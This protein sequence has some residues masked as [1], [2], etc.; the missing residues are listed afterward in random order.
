M[1]DGYFSELLPQLASRSNLA[2]VNQLGFSNAPLRKFLSEAFSNPFG[3]SGSFLADPAFEAVFGWRQAQPTLQ[4][5]AGSLLSPVLVNALDAPQKELAK[6]YR[7]AKKLH[8]YLHQLKAWEILS[9]PEPQSV[10]VA[11]G[12]GSGK[13][14]C[15]MVPILDRLARQREERSGRLAGVRALFL[16][17]LN[18][19]INSQ[20]DRLRAWT[21]SFG[22]DIRFCLYNGNTPEQLPQRKHQEHPNEVLDREALR[23]SPPPILVTNATM[24]EYMLVRTNDKPILDESQGKLEWVVLDEAHT[25]IGSQAAE[26]ALLIRRV[27]FAFGVRSEDVRFVATSATIG[28]PDGKGGER[29]RRFLAETAGVDLERV[30]LISGERQV[31]SLPEGAPTRR[32]SLEVLRGIDA[33]AECSETRY[34]ALAGHQIARSLRN[35]FVGNMETPPIA[36]LSDICQVVCASDS[37]SPEDQREALQWLDLLS[38]T[39]DSEGSCFLPLRA[40]VFHQTLAGLWACSNGACP[41]KT[42]TALDDAAWPFGQVY[43]NP[44]KHCQCG[45]PAYEVVACDECGEVGL[46]AGEAG[47]FLTH[48]QTASVVDEFE[49]EVEVD[50]VGEEE[51]Q[52]EEIVSLA[53]QRKVLVINKSFPHP[54]SLVGEMDIDPKSRR[55]TEASAGALRLRVREAN[56]AGIGCPSCGGRE[57]GR[58]ELFRSARVGAPFLLGNILPTMLEYA[59]DGDQP[60]RHPY[61]GRRLLTFNDS[62]QGAARI[63]AK[64]QQDAERRRVRSLIYHIALQ[65]GRQQASEEAVKLQLEIEQL[66]AAQAPSLDAMIAGKEDKLAALSKPTPI[67]FFKLAQ[68]ISDQGSDF[69]RMLKHYRK[70][71]PEAF[72]II[73]GPTDLARLFLIRE[74]G[75]RPKRQNNLETMGLVAVCYPTLE[76]I[77]DVPL[78]VKQV[79]G[80]TAGDWCDF[81]KLCLDFFIRSGASLGIP[82]SWRRWLGV[83]YP[84]AWVVERDAQHTR[85]KQRR[86]PRARRS[87]LQNTLVRLLTH[88]IGVDIETAEGE[89]CIDIVLQNAWNDLH[90]ANMFSMTADGLVT[91]LDRLAFTPQ[92]AAWICPFTRRLLDTTLKGLSPYLPREVQGSPALCTRVNLPLY[93]EPFGGTAEDLDRVRRGRDWLG[94]Q[95]EIAVLRQEGVWSDLNDRVIELAPFFTAAEHSAQQESSTLSLYEKDFKAG[96]LNLLSCSTTMEMGIDIGGMAM[97][98]MN[99]VP[100]HPANYLQRAGRAGRRKEARSVSMTLCKA[101]PHDQAVFSNSRWAFDTPLPA[102]Q[103]SLDSKLIVQRHIN[104]YLLT[105]YLAQ[106]LVGSSQEKTKLTCGWFFNDPTGLATGFIAWCRAFDPMVSSAIAL[107]FGGLVKHSAFEGYP[108]VRLALQAAEAMEQVAQAWL[109]EW[110]ALEAQEGV[111]SRPGGGS[112]P[113][114]KAVEIHKTRLAG[115]YL[116]RELATRGFLPGYGFPAHISSFDNLTADQLKRIKTV[117]GRED[118]R[119]R[120][121]ELASRDSV[122]ALREYAPG[123]EVVM[124]GLVFR[125][126]G[127]TLN[128]HSPASLQEVREI[129]DIRLAWRCHRCGASGSSHVTDDSRHCQTCGEEIRSENIREFLA[130]AG[131]AVDFYEGPHNDVSRQHFVPVE[132][133]WISVKG[134]WRLL[135]NPCLGRFRATSYGHVFHQSRGIH[136]AGYALCLAC[137]RAEPMGEDGTIPK[138]FQ[139]PHTKLRGGRAGDQVCNGSEDQWKVKRNLTLGH[140]AYTDV[141]ELQ[142]K[143]EDGVWLNDRIVATTLATALRDAVA[144]CLGVQATELGCDIKGASPESGARCQSILIYDHH[145][146]GYSSSADRFIEDVFHIARSR[147][148][149]KANCDSA[150]PSCVLDF[151]QRFLADKLDRHAALN[152]LSEKWLKSFALPMGLEYFGASSRFEYSPVPEAILR[153]AMQTAG[154]TVRLYAGGDPDEWDVGISPLRQLIYRLAGSNWNVEIVL[155]EAAV[156]SVGAADKHLLASLADHPSVKVRLVAATPVGNGGHVIAEVLGNHQGVVWA[157]GDET[158]ITFGPK[159]GMSSLPLVRAYVSSSHELEGQLIGSEVLRPAAIDTGDKELSIHHELD[160][161]LHNFGQRF[162]SLVGSEHMASQRLLADSQASVTHFRYSDRYLFTPL[163]AALLVEL[164]EGVRSIV[165]S[166]RWLSPK[167]EIFTTNQRSF[168]ENYARQTVWADWSDL[169]IRDQAVVYAFSHNEIDASLHGVDKVATKHGRLLEIDFDSGSRL[170]LRLDQGVSYWR[171]YSGRG[172]RATCHFDFDLDSVEQGRRIAQ[173]QV[174]VEGGGWPTEIFVKVRT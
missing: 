111:I 13:T 166:K 108:S 34:R 16:Y 167:L 141:L 45:S 101:N 158:S 106:I 138:A 28:D 20:R 137:G 124:D 18:A 49:L 155:S 89:D 94:G 148:L 12:T 54:G 26:L 53:R 100:P 110:R 112:D 122:T 134:D 162:W 130:P 135:P 119:Y 2:T 39:S 65:E 76:T 36:R 27:L 95:E 172:Q 96:D 70:I 171:A 14:E 90:R 157:F 133:P 35:L 64:L 146:A 143:S 154:T 126:A 150:C 46:L 139:R 102:P 86:W 115:E 17:P 61:R 6:D 152:V 84:Q 33:M 105:H 15:F 88:A 60:A 23:S 56:A 156:A 159:W 104:A 170:S 140:E 25:Y 8:P 51:G 132:A 147:L 48:F 103:V 67:P 77:Q 116:L 91:P 24:L 118:N 30:H 9:Q 93:S 1:L 47:G 58:K 10:V 81:L 151:D 31:P 11:S 160:G 83:P 128:W 99:N 52:I 4:E 168:G 29:L 55:I 92:S 87:G 82:D 74:F 123:S 120:R 21:Q 125:S 149:C 68:L 163:A 164:V 32:D 107:G 97:V 127:I 131:F 7:F 19:L 136:G 57:T 79:S 173:L 73:D 114:L 129:Q 22:G 169:A 63:A 3:E 98:A 69:E 59:P 161:T 117:A 174:Q 85:F 142:L 144:E 50:D 72:N 66:K 145:A 109:A 37:Y 43:F 153:E 62:R 121:R 41:V 5:L 71:A 113:A 44:R 80:F 165:G 40:H 78:E 42:G 75:R 38:M